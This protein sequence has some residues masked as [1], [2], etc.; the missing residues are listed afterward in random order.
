LNA[1]KNITVLLSITRKHG[2]SYKINAL[3]IIG[4]LDSCKDKVKVGASLQ[5]A[6][7]C[8]SHNGFLIKWDEKTDEN[9][10]QVLLIK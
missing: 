5:E 9:N 8:L 7:D 1:S 3:S 6:L 4:K 10:G 2:S